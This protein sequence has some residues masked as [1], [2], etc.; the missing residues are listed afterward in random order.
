MMAFTSFGVS[1]QMPRMRV[2][3]NI[4]I[5]PDPPKA[6]QA[7]KTRKSGNARRRSHDKATAWRGR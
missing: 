7:R 5:P 4:Y 3:E 1:L 6:E 2:Y